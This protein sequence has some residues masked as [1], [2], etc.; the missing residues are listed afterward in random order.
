MQAKIPADYSEI[1]QNI[2]TILDM[3][4]VSGQEL[5]KGLWKS[6]PQEGIMLLSG[7][8]VAARHFWLGLCQDSSRFSR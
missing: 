1:L 2:T 7:P 3:K 5:A 4:D 6:P 8:R